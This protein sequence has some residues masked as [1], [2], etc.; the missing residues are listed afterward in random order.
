[1]GK[2]SVRRER[3]VLVTGA[4][5]GIGAATAL[6]LDER[7]WRVFAGI[8]HPQDAAAL[9]ARASARLTPLPLDITD[10]GQIAAAVETVRAAVGADGLDGVVNNAGIFLGGPVEFMP[11]DNLRQLL[12]V[13]V[14]GTAAV[15]Q[16]FMPLLRQS[17]GRIVNIGSI[18]GRFAMP[19]VAPYAISKFA[20]RALNDALR[21]EVAGWGVRVIIIDPGQVNTAI[22]RKNSE[23]VAENRA[24]ISPQYEAY[25]G[26][27]LDQVKSAD[28]AGQ[29]M[30]P[31]TVA[32]IIHKALT[33]PRPRAHYLVGMDARLGVWLMRLLPTPLF[34]AILRRLVGLA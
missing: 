13:N 5:S 29:G 1:M 3:C 31:A 33:A 2:N 30:P 4:S 20:L 28:E 12:E 27:V 14:L 26:V 6:Y 19:M 11:L 9:R 15:T 23:R 32:A 16:A 24:G 8:R 34:D 25:Y 21:R 17:R 7:G 22:W 10:A 18:N